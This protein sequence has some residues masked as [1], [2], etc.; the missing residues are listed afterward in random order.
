[1]LTFE[2]LSS[3]V[4]RCTR[5][6]TSPFYRDLY[7]ISGEKPLR[8]ASKEEWLALPFFSKKELQASTLPQR[9]FPPWKN[10]DGIVASSG[11]SGNEP[12]FS[13][14]SLNNGFGYRL[15]YHDF[16]KATLSSMPTPQQQEWILAHNPTP[17]RLVMLD[18]K[19]PAASVRLAKAA[20]VDSMFVLSPHLRA[21]GEEI[22]KQN[23]AHHIRFI[24][25][26]GESCSRAS[27]EY[28]QRT[29]PK[30]IIVSFY[31]STDVEASPIAIPCRPVTGEEPL[32]IFHANERFYLE[33]ADLESGNIMPV[34]KGA[35]GDLIVTTDS[36]ETGVFPL[37]RYKIGDTVRIVE[38]QCAQHGGWSFELLGRTEMDFVK[39]PGGVLRA[40]AI[41]RVL[42]ALDAKVKSDLFELHRFE[43][44][45]KDGPMLE[46][47]LHV[48]A[49]G[50]VDL[51]T[52][53]AD[54][55]ELLPV[56][57]G[58]TYAQ[59]VAD[60]RYLPLHCEKFRKTHDI[61]KRKRVIRH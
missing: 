48:E 26:A 20:G 41:E 10:I 4:E 9:F 5:P 42:R 35:E 15:L 54:L 29:F 49:R 1:M 25:L 3:L 6:D 59:G 23:F 24:E 53:A 56:A 27:F 18:P 30:A 16:K 60:G 11:T 51:G 52:L 57:P 33:I 7:G 36:G 34:K 12:V 43:R 22:R 2:Q 55:S 31:G 61:A 28:M 32:E 14:W 46:F 44:E 50:G 19:H 40:E 45:T 39:L 38:E 13:P 17:S 58:Y 21:A 8:I 47:V 37:I